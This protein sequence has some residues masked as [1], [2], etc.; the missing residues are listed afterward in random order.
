MDLNFDIREKLDKFYALPENSD[1]YFHLIKKLLTTKL[2]LDLSNYREKYL[3]RRLYYRI[4]RL[5][6]TNYQQYLEYLKRVPNEASEFKK[7]L[8]IH[9]TQFFRDNTPFRYIEKQ[10]FP[11]LSQIKRF[12]SDKTIRILSA[13]CST[14]EEPYSFAI[15][16][17]FLRKKRIINNPVEIYAYDIEPKVVNMAQ[18][19]IY[20]G[21]SLEKISKLCLL[22]NFTK[23]GDNSYRI[24]PHIKQYVKFGIHDLLKPFKKR[25]FDLIACRN[26][27][28]YIDKPKQKKVI[29][30]LTNNLQSHGFLMLG[31][32]EG[33]PLLS[34]RKF[35]PV[36]IR[37]HFYR[38]KI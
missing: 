18:I 21:E 7:S 27:L 6:I 32:T 26:F 12:H 11:A 30:N 15:I 9:V 20:R 37:E 28:I 29:D 35:E 31:K 8:T 23:I 24:N 25:K 16:A 5:N 1:K 19:G 17:D 14:G 2:D 13:P 36:N 4:L 38:L 22:R 34:I 3:N 33:F 10:L